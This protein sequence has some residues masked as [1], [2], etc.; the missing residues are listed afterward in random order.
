MSSQ[1]PSPAPTHHACGTD[2][3]LKK[4]FKKSINSTKLIIHTKTVGFLGNL[5]R[6]FGFL[7]T[8]II[9][10]FLMLKTDQNLCSGAGFSSHIMWLTSASSPFLEE[11]TPLPESAG[12][13]TSTR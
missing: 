1:T 3:Q 8:S 12:P 5:V 7:K 2:T 9:W 11:L 10:I 13:H 6:K 4:V